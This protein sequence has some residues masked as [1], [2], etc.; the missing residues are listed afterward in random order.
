MRRKTSTY[1]DDSL[2]DHIYREESALSGDHNEAIAQFAP[3][4]GG[5]VMS[6][7]PW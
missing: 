1:I 2:L 3:A 7:I 6:D 5:T 4:L